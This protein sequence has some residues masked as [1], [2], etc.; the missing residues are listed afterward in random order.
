MT[1]APPQVNARS[2]R[3]A[4]FSV[5]KNWAIPCGPSRSQ[6]ESKTAAECRGSGDCPA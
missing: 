2:S 1:N 6:S 5:P 4:A 3:P